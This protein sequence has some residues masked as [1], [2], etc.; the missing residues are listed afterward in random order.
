MIS[1]PNIRQRKESHQKI[2]TKTPIRIL[3]H[4]PPVLPFTEY[5]HYP[6]NFC[7]NLFPSKQ[8]LVIAQ[9]K[10]KWGKES[11]AKEIRKKERKKFCLLSGRSRG[12]PPPLF[13]DQTEAQRAKKI[14]FGD[15]PPPLIQG[16]G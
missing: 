5:F 9:Q 11:K 6:R 14:F 4:F 7:A 10:K 12:G 13:L 16:S 1:T 3:F 8:S 2:N 15:R